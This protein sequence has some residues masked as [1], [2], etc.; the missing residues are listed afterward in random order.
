M[1]VEI[2]QTLKVAL[3]VG[4][5]AINK[6]KQKRLAKAIIEED[7]GLNCFGIAEKI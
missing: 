5:D 4:M 6:R 2:E 7:K 1:T 3:Q